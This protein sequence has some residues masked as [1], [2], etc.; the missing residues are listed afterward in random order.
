MPE[1][2]GRPR[3]R[4]TKL[5]MAKK[6]G[7]PNWGKPEIQAAPVVPTSFEA[8]VKKLRLSPAEYEGSVQLKEW[9]RKN[10]DQKYVPDDLLQFWGFDVKGDL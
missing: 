3:V 1:M 5:T 7:N 8:V 10:K 6:R 9:A 2:R 4:K